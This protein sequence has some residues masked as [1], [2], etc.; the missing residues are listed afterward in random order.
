MNHN[1]DRPAPPT[2]SGDPDLC[3]RILAKLRTVMDS[4]AAQNIVD[5]G[6]VSRVHAEP[7][8]IE[9][10][11]QSTC[12]TCQMGHRF[13]DDV[14]V[15]VRAMAPADTDIYVLPASRPTWES[16]RLDCGK[17]RTKPTCK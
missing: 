4:E 15:A 1:A 3:A 12:S 7:G 11:V 8:T 14:F 6:L 10:S 9:V 17:T 13:L 5:L 2:L 16:V